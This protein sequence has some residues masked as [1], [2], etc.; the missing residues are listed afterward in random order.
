MTDTPKKAT[1]TKV[2]VENFLGARRNVVEAITHDFLEEGCSA[3]AV[4]A[5]A[6]PAFGRDQVIEYLAAVALRQS[7]AKAIAEAGLASVADTG[8]SGIEAPR[9]ALVA[10]SGNAEETADFAA[11]PQRLRQALKEFAIT[12]TVRAG[13]HDDITDDLVDSLLLDG[14]QVRLVKVEPRS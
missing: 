6:S 11:L 10:L 4:A 5:A 8:V 7:A 12:V 9:E 3:R 2:E 14:E 13:E 1:N